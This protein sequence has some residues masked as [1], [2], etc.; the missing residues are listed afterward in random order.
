VFIKKKKE[1]VPL[2]GN[3]KMQETEKVIRN[4]EI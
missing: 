3:K 2:K 4:D 1:L